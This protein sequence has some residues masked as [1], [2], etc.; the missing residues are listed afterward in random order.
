M[1]KMA[2]MMDFMKSMMSSMNAMGHQNETFTG[3]FSASVRSPKNSIG[4]K[5]ANSP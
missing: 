1:L 5:P 2:S 3:C 4:L